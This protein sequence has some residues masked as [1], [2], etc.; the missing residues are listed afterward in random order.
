MSVALTVVDMSNKLSYQHL[1]GELLLKLNLISK[2]MAI[3]NGEYR[4][5]GILIGL[6]NKKLGVAFPSITYLTEVSCLS[7][8]SVLRIL[9]CLNNKGLLVTIK[10]SGRKNRYTFGNILID[11]QTST[12][13]NPPARVTSETSYI[14]NKEKR[15]NNNQIKSIKSFSALK[16]SNNDYKLLFASKY[17]RHKKS[18]K[19]YQANPDIG[20]HLLFRYNKK[21]GLITFPEHNNFT[22]YID[23]FEP[24]TQE[25]KNYS[26]L[27]QKKPEKRDLI[28]LLQHQGLSNEAHMLKILFKKV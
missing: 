19:I 2:K 21:A 13:N 27:K 9:K 25:T 7:R 16:S 20:T 17:W 22:D 23:N 11:Q 1:Q 24:S 26:T 15:T 18:N 6:W 12:I 4:L 14:N 8:S 3:S 10:T 5:M 28:K